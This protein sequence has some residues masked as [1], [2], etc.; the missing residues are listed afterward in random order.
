MMEL[1][2][3][4][5][6]EWFIRALLASSLVGIMCGLLG[7]FVVL[8]N[9]SLIG[10]ALS[11]AVLPGVVFG[12]IFVGG[13]SLLGFFVGSVLAGLIAAVAITWIQDRV[14]TKNDAAIGIVFTAMFSIGVM[15]ISWISRKDGV[16]LDMKDFLFGNVLGVSDAD[17][18]LTFAVALYV[19]LSIILFYRYLFATTFQ[20]VIAETMG[21][22]VKVIHYFLML[23]LA[24]A[25]VASLRTVGV[26][27]VVAMLI[28]PAA[29]ALLLTDR[30]KKV[31]WLSALFGL[32]SAV[33]GLLLSYVYKTTPGPAMTVT[34]TVFY[35][36]AVF[37]APE[38][39]LL[40]Q[41]ITS[42]QNKRKI[43][44][45]DTLKQSLKL[46]EREN[47]S[48]ENLKKRLGFNSST[49]KTYVSR[50]VKQGF[51][52][53]KSGALQ[54]TTAGEEAATVLVRKHRMWES[55]L[56]SEMGISPNQIHE[57]AEKYEHIL[58]ED[59]V[60]ELD[61]KL[62][63]PELDPHGAPI[64]RNKKILRLKL[65]EIEDGGEAFIIREQLNDTIEAQLWELGLLPDAPLEIIAVEKE[66][67]QVEQGKRRVQVPVSLA[68]EIRMARSA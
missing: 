48:L 2:E 40:F 5:Q 68:S 25:V 36:I 54:L 53:K 60:D 52:S 12:F 47:L 39:G 61:K 57:D 55:Y 43:Q 35:L 32:L 17:I 24:F 56:V 13:Y 9:M 50:L 3:V 58:T 4:F 49:L 6:A 29:T 7:A 14:K 38:K 37:F 10:D 34:A 59:M 33:V 19:I 64:P 20:P 44:F 45:E 46:H 1:F 66:F 42:R 26:I 51:L 16:H 23:L 15:G 11:H 8:R 41:S 62:G 21:F 67:V 27:L 63:F 65:S 22:N 31:L 28:T 18:W 30:M